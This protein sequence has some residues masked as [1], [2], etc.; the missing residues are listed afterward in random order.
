MSNNIEIF[1]KSLLNIF[2]CTTCLF[3]SAGGIQARSW[4]ADQAYIIKN[5]NG[6]YLGFFTPGTHAYVEIPKEGPTKLSRLDAYLYREKTSQTD[7]WTIAFSKTSGDYN[8]GLNVFDGIYSFKPNYS[9][10]GSETFYSQIYE[11]VGPGKDDYL[12][13]GDS[14]LVLDKSGQL[15]VS[16]LIQKAEAKS[17]KYNNEFANQANRAW[18]RYKIKFFVLSVEAPPKVGPTLTIDLVPVLDEE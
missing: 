8:D 9:P 2:L 16:P 13:I 18:G 12:F 5:H 11:W 3:V 7:K 14:K 1:R 4:N 10:I 6:K 15:D 17:F